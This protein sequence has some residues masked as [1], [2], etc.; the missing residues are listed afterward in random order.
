MKELIKIGTRESK[1]AVWQ[2]VQ[3]K[4]Y[5]DAHQLSN[6]MVYIKSEGDINLITPLYDL[7]VQGIFTKTLDIALLEKRID[8]AVH[9][10]KDVPT[11]LAKGLQIAAV[12]KRGNPFDVLVCR[13]GAHYELRNTNHGL[14]TDHLPL[15]PHDSRFTIATSSTRR[16]AQWLH[17][18]PNYKI[19]NLR[20]NVITRI[21]KVKESN[22]QGA[23]FAAAGLERLGLTENETGPQILLD[24]MLPAPA[25]GAVVIVCREKDTKMLEICA[26]LNDEPTQIC[27]RIERNFLKLLQGGCSTPIGAFAEIIGDEVIFRG[28][29]TSVDGSKSISVELKE[30][31]KMA[32]TVA[33]KASAEMVAKGGRK[34]LV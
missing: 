20:G 11:Q 2:A 19:E 5:L 15:K 16:K 23:I 6:E 32:Y 14:Q 27:T 9:S 10:H 4:D 3:V 22:W 25:Q 21:Q 7:G 13:E 34:L 29:V 31:L 33:L 18:H 24:W 28:N 8:I 26:A 17:R 1:L 12:L 30:K